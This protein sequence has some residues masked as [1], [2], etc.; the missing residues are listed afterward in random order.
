MLASLIVL[1]TLA[2]GLPLLVAVASNLRNRNERI[3]SN[4][5]YHDEHKEDL[6]AIAR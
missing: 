4:R 3:R 5:A 1:A 2:I 6:A